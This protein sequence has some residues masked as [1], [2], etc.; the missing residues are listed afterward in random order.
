MHGGSCQRCKG[1]RASRTS[2]TL[3]PGMTLHLYC[4][5]CDFNCSSVHFMQSLDHQHVNLLHAQHRLCQHSAHQRLQ[6]SETDTCDAML[7]HPFSLKL[8]PRF[9]FDRDILSA[10]L[11]GAFSLETLPSPLPPRHLLSG[12][13][14]KIIAMMGIVAWPFWLAESL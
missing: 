10:H 8:S 14:I 5:S 1:S 12:F 13:F 6:I 2:P 11:T 9:L 7:Q 3:Y 4:C